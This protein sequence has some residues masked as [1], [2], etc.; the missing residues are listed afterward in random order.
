MIMKKLSAIVLGI[1]VIMLSSCSSPD[2]LIQNLDKAC[3]AGDAEKVA[4]IAD[5]L[6][7]MNDQGKL[8]KEQNDEFTKVVGDCSDD[9]WEK[10]IKLSSEND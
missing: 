4:K 6:E 9:V 1:G 8:T 5:K 2:S 7:D 3:K 10:A